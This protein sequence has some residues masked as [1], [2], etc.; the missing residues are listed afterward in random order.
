MN[1]DQIIDAI[2][3]GFRDGKD[4]EAIFLTREDLE[5]V[6]DCSRMIAACGE[7]EAMAPLGFSF[8]IGTRNYVRFGDGSEVSIPV[9]S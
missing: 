4:V 3:Q 9:E 7:G 5:E 2:E 8:K 6:K 1:F